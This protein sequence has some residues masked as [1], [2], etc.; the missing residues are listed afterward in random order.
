MV[1]YWVCD[2]KI[3]EYIFKLLGILIKEKIFGFDLFFV[4]YEYNKDNIDIKIFLFGV[5]EGVVDCVC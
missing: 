1:D 5:K 3:I 2:S 4:F